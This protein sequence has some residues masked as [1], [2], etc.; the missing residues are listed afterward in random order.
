MMYLRP[1]QV[2][3]SIIRGLSTKDKVFLLPGYDPF[4]EYVCGPITIIA[5]PLMYMIINKDGFDRKAIESHLKDHAYQLT[6]TAR[7]HNPLFV[8]CMGYPASTSIDVV[9]LILEASSPSESYVTK[10]LELTLAL[11]D[12]QAELVSL[13]LPYAPSII[14]NSD[15]H[16]QMLIRAVDGR[17]PDIVSLLL[18]RGFNVNV[19][20]QHTTPLLRAI[21]NAD[22]PV[23]SLLLARGADPN[24]SAPSSL[25][26]FNTLI[27][28]G[29][30]ETSR[31]MLETLLGPRCES[32]DT[33]IAIEFVV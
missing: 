8:A 21:A 14:G 23:M 3:L 7:G 26:P 33:E 13:L 16:T 4:R 24:L 10:L 22:V 19:C 17:R 2:M 31:A 1:M 30:N 6:M 11:T 15:T 20:N 18:D 12:P 32:H 5:T 25:S 27:G 29:D 28:M 9:E